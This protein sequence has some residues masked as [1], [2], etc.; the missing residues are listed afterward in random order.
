MPRDR[1]H[2]NFGSYSAVVDMCSIGDELYAAV[3]EGTPQVLKLLMYSTTREVWDI[4]LA[5]TTLY[6]RRS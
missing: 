5:L 4:R 3:L 6:P 2:N 1:D